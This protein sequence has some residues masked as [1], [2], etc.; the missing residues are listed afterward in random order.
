MEFRHHIVGFNAHG[1]LFT[2][3]ITPAYGL[4]YQ[5][6]FPQVEGIIHTQVLTTAERLN[7]LLKDEYRKEMAFIFEY[8]NFPRYFDV[9]DTALSHPRNIGIYYDNKGSAQA[10]FVD[11]DGLGDLGDLQRIQKMVDPGG[12]L[13]RW[14]GIYN[15]WLAGKSKKYE[16]IVNARIDIML[17]EGIA[18]FWELIERG[19]G[20]AAYPRNGPFRTLTA[21]QSTYESE[22]RAAYVRTLSMVKPLVSSSL[23]AYQGITTV[24]YNNM[25]FSGQTY[26]SNVGEH[27]FVISGTTTLDKIGRAAGR[28]FVLN[29]AGNVLRKWSGWLPKV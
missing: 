18:P 19:N 7:Q 3:G 10:K 11:L 17:G 13:E 15:S 20:P 29:N 1:I 8:N 24:S 16:E 28:G 26:T 2:I 6:L 12:T 4:S 25:T 23:A 22:M 14:K 27:I 9:I 21:F 5:Q